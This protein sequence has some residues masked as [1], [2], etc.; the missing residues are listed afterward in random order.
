MRPLWASQARGYAASFA[1]TDLGTSK[2]KLWTRPESSAW[3]TS[4]RSTLETGTG[5]IGAKDDDSGN[6][7]HLLQTSSGLRPTRKSNGGFYCNATALASPALGAWAGDFDVWMAFKSVTYST[8]YRVADADFTTGFG[9]LQSVDRVRFSCAN[10]S[11]PYGTDAAAAISAGVHIVHC[12]R[13][14]TTAS[15]SVDGA[16]PATAT[17]TGSA[18]SDNP[19]VVGL[20]TSLAYGAEID[21]HEIAVC[22]G[23]SAGERTSMDAYFATRLSSGVYV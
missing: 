17:V 3:Q 6:A 7:R 9:I 21:M 4:A 15:I 18:L 1:P 5:V 13:A 16:A 11:A 20:S 19:M 2:L 12:W 14:G 22:A 10:A 23:I 8:N